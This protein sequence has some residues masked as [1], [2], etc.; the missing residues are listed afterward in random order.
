MK[1]TISPNAPDPAKE[2]CSSC[3]AT[4]SMTADG[5]IVLGHNTMNEFYYPNTNFI[6]DILPEKRHRILMRANSGFI[7]S[8]TDFF[9]TNA[10]LIGSET[11]I[12]AF[13]PFDET[14]IPEFARMRSVTQ[15]AAN[16]DEWCGIMK[17]GNNG[18]YANAW[19]LGDISTNEIARLELELKNQRLHAVSAGNN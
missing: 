19:L 3:I 11:T 7:H 13:F 5:N 8:G 1:D 15:Y 18:G 9:V 10:G 16:I 17:K 6:L 12:G 14:G 4:G 2:S